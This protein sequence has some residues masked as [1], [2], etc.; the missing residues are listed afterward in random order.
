MSRSRLI[1][2][3][4]VTTL[5]LLAT[6][7]LRVASSRIFYRYRSAYVLS[8]RLKRQLWRN[9]LHLERLKDSGLIYETVDVRDK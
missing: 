4:F 1:F 3:V 5:M 9:Q 7:H 8:Q 2:V 6:V